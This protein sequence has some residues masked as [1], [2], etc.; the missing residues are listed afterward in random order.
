MILIARDALAER[1]EGLR[2]G[3]DDYLCKF[4]ALI[5]VVV[6]LEVLMRR[7]NG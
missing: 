4:F 6:R 2:L 7:I 1:V 5:E 3:V